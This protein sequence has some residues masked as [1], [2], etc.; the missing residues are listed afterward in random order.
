MICP[1]TSLTSVRKMAATQVT[2]LPVKNSFPTSHGLLMACEDR[3]GIPGLCLLNGNADKADA[4]RATV[5][6]IP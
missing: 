5:A 2:Q 6:A 4:R 1:V 3:I